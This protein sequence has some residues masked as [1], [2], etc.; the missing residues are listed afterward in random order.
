LHVYDKANIIMWQYL[1]HILEEITLMKSLI[2]LVCTVGLL[3]AAD[4][5]GTWKLDTAK[6]K[7][8]GTPAP[9]EQTVTITAN[10]NG[11]DYM[12]MG[13]SSTGEAIHSTFTYVK[14]GEQTKTTGFPN[15]DAVV[16]KHGMENKTEFEFLRGGK[17]VGGGTRVLEKDGKMYTVSG[18]VKLADGKEATYKSVYVKQ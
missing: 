17:K 10:G 2:L 12:A 11:Y 14:D 18:K 8:E 5:T 4:L 9:K 6:S 3:S 7:Y 1:K 15:W 13:T 16:F